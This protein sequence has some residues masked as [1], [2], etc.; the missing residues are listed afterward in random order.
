MRKITIKSS[1]LASKLLAEQ[2]ALTLLQAAGKRRAVSRGCFTAAWTSPAAAWGAQ[3]SL[4][5]GG[6]GE[7]PPAAPAPLSC[8]SPCC[9]GLHGGG[10]AGQQQPAGCKGCTGHRG[11]G[12]RCVCTCSPPEPGQRQKSGSES[13]KRCC[14]GVMS[15]PRQQPGIPGQSWQDQSQGNAAFG[16]DRKVSSGSASP[17]CARSGR[18]AAGC[19]RAPDPSELL[20][21]DVPATGAV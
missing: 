17:S 14:R 18:L 19:Q 8:P 4:A 9:P 3:G 1:S 20:G 2:V 12:A 16:A 5:A 11:V 13:P 6:L 7:Q 21:G 10:S 15:P